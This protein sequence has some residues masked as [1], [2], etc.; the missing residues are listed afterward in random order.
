MKKAREH[1]LEGD[2]I[3]LKLKDGTLQT[4]LYVGTREYAPHTESHFIM[5]DPDHEHFGKKVMYSDR[6]E[7]DSF[8]KIGSIGHKEW[9]ELAESR[10]VL[11]RRLDL[12]RQQ[13]EQ[14]EFIR[15]FL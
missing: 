10:D 2:I 6:F 13:V 8:Q 15:E 3:D 12:M 7:V 9:K 14:P 5:A 11:K 4:L 1:L